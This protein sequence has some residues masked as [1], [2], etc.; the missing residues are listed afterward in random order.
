MEFPDS[1][2]KRKGKLELTYMDEEGIQ[3]WEKFLLWVQ[4]RLLL[5]NWRVN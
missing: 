4:V 2:L 1:K 5:Q 3:L